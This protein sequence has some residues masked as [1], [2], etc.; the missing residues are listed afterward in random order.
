MSLSFNRDVSIP[1]TTPTI[2]LINAIFSDNSHQI[3]SLSEQGVNLNDAGFLNI[4]PLL[5]AVIFGKQKALQTLI[6]CGADKNIKDKQGRTALDL[7]IKL[8]QPEILEILLQ[9]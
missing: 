4:P 7:A 3:K 5:R 6:E 1:M 9:N 8:N 2:Q